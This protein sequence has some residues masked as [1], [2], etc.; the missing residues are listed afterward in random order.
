MS[1]HLL[2][3]QARLD[4][5]NCRQGV[6]MDRLLS[7]QLSV[8]LTRGIEKDSRLNARHLSSDHSTDEIV[9]TCVYVDILIIKVEQNGF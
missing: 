9:Q 4:A 6:R 7:F 1:S 8:P 5:L 2:G 3:F